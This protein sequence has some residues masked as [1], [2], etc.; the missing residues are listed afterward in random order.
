MHF[1]SIYIIHDGR[2]VGFPIF[3]QISYT[4]LRWQTTRVREIIANILATQVIN[5]KF[6][7]S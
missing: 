3:M 7:E 4:L 6:I 1:E 2:Y 5:F